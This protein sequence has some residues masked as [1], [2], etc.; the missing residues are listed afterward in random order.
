MSFRPWKSGFEIEAWICL[1][2]DMMGYV[3]GGN[4]VSGQGFQLY[5][6][7]WNYYYAP[8]SLYLGN[9]GTVPVTNRVHNV[10]GLCTL[11]HSESFRR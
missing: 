1:Q 8:V 2:S 5:L 9:W 3:W 7:P 6:T 4:I 10:L 11:G